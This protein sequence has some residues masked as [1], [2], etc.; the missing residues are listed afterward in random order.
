M[1]YAEL[2]PPLCELREHIEN[3]S[4][5]GSTSSSAARKH[6]RILDHHILEI[7]SRHPDAVLCNEHGFHHLLIVL[8]IGKNAD[9]NRA[10]HPAKIT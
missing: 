4:K 1:E 2:Q 10:T 8:P 9:R 7:R 6:P 5:I 3:G